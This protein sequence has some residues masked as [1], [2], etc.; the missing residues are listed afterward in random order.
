M[1]HSGWLLGQNPYLAAGMHTTGDDY[2]MFLRA[3]LSYEIV[4]KEIADEMER[5][6]LSPPYVGCPA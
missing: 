5:D 4:P 3:Y 2:D 6:Y 1:N